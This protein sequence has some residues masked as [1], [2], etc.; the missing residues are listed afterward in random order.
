MQF[1]RDSGGVQQF[2]ELVCGVCV[3]PPRSAG[4]DAWVHAY[5][6]EDE[7]LG[8]GILEESFFLGEGGGL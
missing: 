6:E 3:C 4:P 8:D 2:P 1:V 7:V 5:Q